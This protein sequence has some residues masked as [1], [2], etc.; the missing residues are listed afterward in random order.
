MRSARLLAL[1]AVPLILA[2]GACAPTGWFDA[3]GSV[4]VPTGASAEYV[5]LPCDEAPAD[6]ASAA[7]DFSDI[8]EGTQ[9][10]VENQDAE[11]IASGALEAGTLVDEGGETLL[12]SYPFTLT[13]VPETAFYSI[14]VGD[15]SRGGVQFTQEEMQNGPAIALQ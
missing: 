9:V 5:G 1:P 11:T 7:G 13:K 12:C 14:L 6:D 2:L 15:G 10:V 4:T 8:G 3:V